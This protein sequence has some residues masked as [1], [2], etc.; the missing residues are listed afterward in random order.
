MRLALLTDL[1]ANLEALEAVLEH[2]HRQGAEQ[3]AF[4]GDLVGYGADPGPVVDRVEAAVATGALAIKGNHDEAATRGPPPSMVPDAARA[5][6]WTREHLTRE[7]LAFLAGLPLTVERGERLFVHG[8]AVDPAHWIY[9]LSAPDAGRSLR[10]VRAREVFSGHTHTPALYH[11]AADGAIGAFKPVPGTRIKLT[12]F[13]RW[14]VIPGSVGQP[15]DGNP[16]ACYAM[17]DDVADILVYHRVPYD[18][19]RA[20]RKIRAA[21]LPGDLGARLELGG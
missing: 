8:S 13:H 1:H 9:V 21:G 14:L 16:A 17:L 7:Q 6:T 18:A 12:A 4:L 15:R 2:A 11:L 5:V 20:A 19:E 10:A 3:F